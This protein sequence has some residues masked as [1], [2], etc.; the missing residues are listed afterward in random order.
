[1]FI[2]APD[3]GTAE[4]TPEETRRAI[5]YVAA[6]LKQRLSCKDPVSGRIAGCQSQGRGQ[7][8]FPR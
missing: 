8:C 2:L 5:R 7:W 6:A 3:Q 1:M 4:G